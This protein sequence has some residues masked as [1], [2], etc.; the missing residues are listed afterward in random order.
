MV[1][2]NQELE[3]A[4]QFAEK[5]AMEKAE[6]LATM[7]HEIRTPMNGV[8]GMANILAEENLSPEQSENL[9]VLRFSADNLLNLINDVLDLAK[10]E[11]GKIQLEK[12]DFCIKEYYKKTYQVFKTINKSSAVDIKLGLD[13]DDLNCNLKGDVLRINQVVTNLINN[14]L[15]FT[16]K[17]SVTFKVSKVNENGQ[18]VTIKFEIIDT[19]IGISEEKQKTIFEK[20]EQA[21]SDTSRKYGGTGLGLNICKEIIKLHDSELQLISKPG[22]GSNFFFEIEFEKSDQLITESRVEID[23]SKTSF[24]GLKILLAEDNKVN[25]IVAKRIL[26]NWGVDLVVAQNGLEALNFVKSQDFDLILMDIQMPKMDGFEATSKIRQLA[27]QKGK[28]PILAMTAAQVSEIMEDVKSNKMDGIVTK[29]FNPQMLANAIY[30]HASKDS[31]I[32]NTVSYTHL[33]LPT[34]PYV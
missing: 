3:K 17:G 27:G 9:E 16:K 14:A 33:T 32:K 25:Q 5:A 30:K 11:A 12:N 26:R 24:K 34:T 23:S 8:I 19:G 7:S 1:Q 4:K 6:F 18:T 22:K 20:F 28:I 21:S 10:F 2:K 13:L 31:I 15:K 29:P